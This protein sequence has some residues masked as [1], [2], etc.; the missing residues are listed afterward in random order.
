MAFLASMV[1]LLIAAGQSG[2]GSST[3]IP[4][5]TILAAPDAYEGQTVTIQGRV[6]RAERA[7]FPNGRSYYTLSIGRDGATLTVFSWE[8]PLVKEGDLIETVGIFHVWRYNFHY[9]IESVRI[10]RLGSRGG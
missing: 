8:R 5:A 4:T 1:G 3:P 10:T 9:V 7:V 6:A 2:G